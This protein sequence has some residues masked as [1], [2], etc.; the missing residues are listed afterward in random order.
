M[1][2]VSEWTGVEARALRLASRRSV[3]TFAGDLGV[4]VR[5]V[6]NWERLGAGTRPRPDTQAILD[7]ALGR[8]DQAGIFRFEAILSRSGRA[9]AVEVRGGPRAWE[10]ETWTEDIERAVVAASRQDFVVASDLLERWRTRWPA[11][12]LDERGLYLFARTTA[13]AGDL[14]RDRGVLLGPRSAVRSYADARSVFDQLGVP[15]RVAQLDLSLA[16]VAEMSGDLR[17]AAA[18]YD[19]LGRD[20]RLSGRDRLRAQLWVGTALD[21]QG[22]HEAAM[23]LMTSAILGFEGLGEQED[24]GT[25]HQKL[26]LAHRGAGN[27]AEA[28]R[29]ISVA[30]SAG[31]STSPLHRVRLATAHGHV[32]LSDRA[33]V[34]EG[35]A[36][37]DKAA[38]TAAT[39]GMSHQLRSIDGIRKELELG[40]GK[41]KFR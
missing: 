15:R 33:T 3:R 19:E 24:W 11:R 9:V 28:G 41:T 5:T 10:Y 8:L 25:A 30:Q 4:A 38:A 6:T 1:A 12:E 23:P 35:L 32:L 40:G 31:D 39:Y 7:T 22:L 17:G 26:A 27:L 20:D 16:V 14:L 37:L 2:A 21:K 18:R 34:S 36:A 13:L 29:L